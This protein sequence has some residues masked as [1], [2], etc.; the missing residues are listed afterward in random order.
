MSDIYLIYAPSDFDRVRE[1]AIALQDRGYSVWRERPVSVDEAGE[2]ESPEGLKDAKCV[3]A[4]WSRASVNSS[5]VT[6]EAAAAAQSGV[7]LE[8]RIDPVAVPSGFGSRTTIDLTDWRPEEPH[9]GI[10]SL[11]DAVR[12][13]VG[14]PEFEWSRGVLTEGSPKGVLEETMVGSSR[15][16]EPEEAP[17]A[18]LPQNPVQFSVY[19]P[20]DMRPERW[21]TLLS[22]I[23]LAAVKETV[24][25]DS[26]SRLPTEEVFRQQTADANQV[27]AREAEIRVVPELPGCR[28]NPTYQQVIWIED[29]HRAEFRVQARPELPGFALE[30]PVMGRVAFYV[31]TVLVGEVPIWAVLSERAVA[32]DVDRPAHPTIADPYQAI[33]VSYSHRDSDVVERIGRAYKALGMQFLR[34]VEM[35]R[36]GE[37]WNPRLLEYI[38]KADI[39][40]LYWSKQAKASVYVQQEWHHALSLGRENFIRPLYWHTPMPQPPAELG[41]LHFAYYPAD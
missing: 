21:Y 30:Q 12:Q 25:A 32:V 37:E 2:P 36:S 17:N 23:H 3:I 14:A 9:G 31:Q 33:F 8:V 28:F 26:R 1:L 27:I 6:Q 19:H 34:D 38:E 35:L 5:R 15:H 10:S 40:Q 18:G 41:A 22:Y 13:L 11:L 24:E 7:L 39:F 20:Q 16:A 29:W 4:L